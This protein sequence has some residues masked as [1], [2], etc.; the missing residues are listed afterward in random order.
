MSGLLHRP[1]RVRYSPS[2]SVEDRYKK[3][4][5]LLSGSVLLNT[6][7]NALSS[8]RHA[9]S[10]TLLSISCLARYF[11]GRRRR[12]GSTGA[13]WGELTD[14]EGVVT[15]IGWS[16]F[17]KNVLILA[18]KS[19]LLMNPTCFIAGVFCPFLKNRMVGKELT[20]N[21]LTSSL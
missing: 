4:L 17:F 7:S 1:V 3:V 18:S 9:G 10:L 2:H 8:L 19:S 14:E 5:A 21:F 16:Y 13:A 11:A 20:L 12:G 6:A 15:M